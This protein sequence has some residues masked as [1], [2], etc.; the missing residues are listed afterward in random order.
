MKRPKNLRDRQAVRDAILDD[1][2]ADRLEGLLNTQK[3]PER[4]RKA[5]E[6]RAVVARERV[7]ARRKAG[8]AD[9]DNRLRR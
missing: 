7:Q 5:I 2:H 9:G 8:E 4:A 1:L 3:L 6:A